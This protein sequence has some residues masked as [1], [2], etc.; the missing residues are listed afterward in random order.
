MDASRLIMNYGLVFTYLF[1]LILSFFVDIV[2]M[3]D[4]TAGD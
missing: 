1:L 3:V 2:V 4:Q